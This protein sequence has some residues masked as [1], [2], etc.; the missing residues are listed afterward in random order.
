MYS[1]IKRSGNVKYVGVV[2]DEN[3]T[4]NIVQ[5]SCVASLSCNKK[6]LAYLE[7]IFPKCYLERSSIKF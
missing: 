5:V 3:I 2:V 4:G 7:E 6:F 1:D